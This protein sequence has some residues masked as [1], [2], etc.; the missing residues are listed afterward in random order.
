M[1]KRESASANFQEK[2][3]DRTFPS[4]RSPE[5][6]QVRS[7]KR[8]FPREGQHA[9]KSKRTIP[10]DSFQA[11]HPMRKFPGARS[12]A[13]VFK[14][15]TPSESLQAKSPRAGFQ[16]TVLKLS[17]GSKRG[18]PNETPKA[19]AYNRT[20]ENEHSQAKG[21]IINCP[22]EFPQTKVSRQTS[23]Q[24]RASERKLPSEQNPIEGLQAR[25]PKRKPQIE[26]S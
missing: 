6:V 20:I 7:R 2:S 17:I 22:F 25:V 5:G 18:F 24:A 23:R 12:Q 11:K 9:K 16:A 1:S 13:I 4:E 10:N 21:P 3:P 15:K 26:S 8:K 19:R 14:R